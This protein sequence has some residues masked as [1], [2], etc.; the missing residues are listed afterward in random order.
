MQKSHSKVIG[1]YSVVVT[2]Y[3]PE[4]NSPWFC[5]VYRI[6]DDAEF[7]LQRNGY[8]TADEAMAMGEAW[9]L[10]HIKINPT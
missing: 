9:T 8:A 5:K 2:Q 1:R 4:Q 3:V 10:E 6:S 7:S